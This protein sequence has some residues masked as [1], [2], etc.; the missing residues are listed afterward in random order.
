MSRASDLLGTQKSKTATKS[1]SV[2][3]PKKALVPTVRNADNYPAFKQGNKHE[4]LQTLL[5]NTLGNTFYADSKKLLSDTHRIHAQMVQTDPVFVAKAAMYARVFGY[6]RMQPQIALATLVNNTAISTKL[7][8]Q[9]FN[10]IIST[11]K[12]LSDFTAILNGMGKSESGRRVQSA[13]KAWLTRFLNSN[14]A[15]YWAIK[16]GAGGS[17]A[18]KF[19]LADLI[20]VYHP[21]I[22]NRS[23]V[24]YLLG[25]VSPDSNMLFSFQK[26]RWDSVEELPQISAYQRLK[27][28][29]TPLEKASLI[30]HGRLPRDVARYFAGDSKVVWNAIGSQM[31]VMDLLK[32]LANLERRGV[33]DDLRPY[34]ESVLG[35]KE[36]IQSAKILP[37]RYLDAME[38]VGS[39]YWLKDIL[40]QAVEYSFDSVP[41]I[42]GRTAIFLDVSG[43]MKPISSTTN[44]AKFKQAAIFAVALAK[45]TKNSVIALG[46][47]TKLYEIPISTVDSILTQ[48]EQIERLGGGGTSTNLPIERLLKDK[49]KV[50]QI[51]LITDEQQNSGRGFYQVLSD[52]RQRVNPNTT[53]V[54]INVDPPTSSGIVPNEP[55]NYYVYGW[56]DSV[57]TYAY[58][59]SQGW[60]KLT[61]MIENDVYHIITAKYETAQNTEVEEADDT[62]ETEET[63]ES[64]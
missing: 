10:A 16:Y 62:E 18:G 42:E 20:K 1:K 45:K 14:K 25:E 26:E 34:I 31:P 63:E 4:F 17:A 29:K 41:P 39:A 49:T 5:T 23:L 60:E 56:S 52:Y 46:F 38:H 36:R 11:P 3:A 19:S 27:T 33:L 28:A 24:A 43:S 58:L 37:Y 22:N 64:N 48:V 13:G 55:N 59:A 47:D 7:F 32:N 54:V 50:D 15:E 40:R 35:S 61:K 21:R 30:T 44:A 12:D 8:N 51:F 6:M 9:A 53:C 57:L 2:K